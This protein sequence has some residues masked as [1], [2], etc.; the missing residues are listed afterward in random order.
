MENELY[1][2]S[3]HWA[4]LKRARKKTTKAYKRKI[5]LSINSISR[6]TNSN[7]TNTIKYFQCKTRKNCIRT[8]IKKTKPSYATFHRRGSNETL[9]LYF[10][11]STHNISDCNLQSLLFPV[12]KINWKKMEKCDI[13]IINILYFNHVN[14][15]N[16]TTKTTKPKIECMMEV[17]Q[18]MKSKK[19][20]QNCDPYVA[21]VSEDVIINHRQRT[22]SDYK[23]HMTKRSSLKSKLLQKLHEIYL[24][25]HQASQQRNLSAFKCELLIFGYTNSVFGH[26]IVSHIPDVISNFIMHFYYFGDISI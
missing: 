19:E 7:K 23:K 1:C 13:D 15:L 16:C 25:T 18:Y 5:K 3:K 14:S 24:E 10:T 8:I 2:N 12:H 20:E 21:D 6:K 9:N 4:Y 26:D 22:H 17:K 11:N